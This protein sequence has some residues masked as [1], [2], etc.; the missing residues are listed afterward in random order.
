MVVTELGIF[1][2]AKEMAFKYFAPQSGMNM[3]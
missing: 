2:A 1:H 3:S